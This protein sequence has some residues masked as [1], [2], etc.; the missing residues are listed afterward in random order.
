MYK[1]CLKAIVY[2]AERNY[3]ETVVTFENG[4]KEST[5]M[6]KGKLEVNLSKI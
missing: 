4:H 1:G 3:F 5:Y 6:G 2:F